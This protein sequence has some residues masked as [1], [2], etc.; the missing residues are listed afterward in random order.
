MATAKKSQK[1]SRNRKKIKSG[2]PAINMLAGALDY[3]RNLKRYTDLLAV[4]TKPIID[5]VEEVLAET[6]G[7]PAKE[8]PEDSTDRED[9]AP[10]TKQLLAT[11]TPAQ[12][13][14]VQQI[15]KVVL[16]QEA[17]Y[18][19]AVD[20]Q[21]ARKTATRAHTRTDKLNEAQVK[22]QLKAV[23][24]KKFKSEKNKKIRGTFIRENVKLI[25]SIGPEHFDRIEHS[26]AEGFAAGRRS[27]AIAK[28]LRSI[29][30]VTKRRAALIA[31]DQT[32]S[33]NGF[34]TRDR[35]QENGI[36]KFLWTTVGDEGVRS[37]HEDLEGL[38]FGWKDG[39]TSGNTPAGVTS[40]PGDTGQGFPGTPIQCRCYAEPVL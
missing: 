38:E 16:Q 30:G 18:S 8:E 19:N 40:A 10:T 15:R 7:V 28:D 39:A 12:R 21:D 27:S 13:L 25:G 36:T 5:E 3:F 22:K 37:S 29:N 11:L 20:L 34:L 24:V 1:K 31:R 32:A 2:V 9:A 17:K 35:H 6:G 33:L 4:L 26:I 14:Q 23:G